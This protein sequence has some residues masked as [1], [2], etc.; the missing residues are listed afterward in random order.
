MRVNVCQSCTHQ[1]ACMIFYLYIPF[2]PVKA[3]SYSV[4]QQSGGETGDCRR[5]VELS[6]LVSQL[7][8][9]NCTLYSMMHTVLQ[10]RRTVVPNS[11]YIIQS[12]LTNFAYYY[13]SI[14]YICTF[15]FLLTIFY[16]SSSLNSLYKPLSLRLYSSSLLSNII[17]ERI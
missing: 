13:F 11:F 9:Y 14:I 1:Y 15:A 12:Q 16:N 6:Q 8:T 5:R 7:V 3:Y 4:Q 10:T 17:Q 2:I